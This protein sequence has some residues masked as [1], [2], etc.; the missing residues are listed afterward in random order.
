MLG[1]L[2]KYDLKYMIK[3]MGVFYIL[4]IVFS[5]L[6][7]IF[8]AM[9]QTV[10]VG[11]IGQICVGFMFAM[12][13][14]TIINTV[15]RSWVRFRD[16]LYKDEAYLTHT[17][18]VTKKQIYESRFIQTLI[19]TIVGFVIVVVSLFIA[20]Y[21]EDRWI[22]L[23]NTINGLSSSLNLETIP[24]IISIF[25]IVFLEIFNGIQSG[26]LGII[27]GYRRDDNKLAFSVIFGF[28]IYIISQ[29]FVILFVF[30][31][32]LFNSNIMDLFRN[33]MVLDNS[34][35]RLLIVMAILI[36]SIIIG[37]MNMLCCIELKK[38][39]NIE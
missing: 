9:K 37:V 15:I 27:V 14:S 22:M 32:G 36:Y 5:L 10:I 34:S 16:S 3:N 21:T 4:A 8:F 20:Y 23:R 12:I 29:I 18:P 28:I 11:I 2:L 6:T 38:G 26:F 39:V 35:I 31:V 13:F 7:R 1:K 17:L 19:F 24:F 25:V 33:T 30:I